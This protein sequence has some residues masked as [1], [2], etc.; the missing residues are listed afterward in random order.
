VAFRIEYFAPELSSHSLLVELALDLHKHLHGSR[1]VLWCDLGRSAD[2]H[3]HPKRRIGQAQSLGVTALQYIDF[4]ARVVANKYG[5]QLS[6]HWQTLFRRDTSI[7]SLRSESHSARYH[8]L[9]AVPEDEIP[10]RASVLPT[11]I[12]LSQ[13]FRLS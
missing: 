12:R 13:E 6:D 5:R 11:A 9:N 4:R 1:V 7:S 10:R 2:I 8:S 3:D